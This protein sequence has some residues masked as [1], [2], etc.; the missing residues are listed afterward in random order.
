MSKNRQFGVV[1][2]EGLEAM[3]IE[4]DIK[5]AARRFFDYRTDTKEG[6]ADLDPDGKSFGL[7]LFGPCAPG[8]RHLRQCLDDASAATIVATGHGLA[9]QPPVIALA[10]LPEER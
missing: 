10:D 6:M 2:M 9:D 5:G 4:M 1:E 8:R 3:T 7:E